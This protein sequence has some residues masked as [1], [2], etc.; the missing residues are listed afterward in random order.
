MVLTPLNHIRLALV[1]SALLFGALPLHADPSLANSLLQQ[2]R[3]DAASA[4]L[5]HALTSQPGDGQAHQLL[6]RVYYSQDM[7]DPAIHEC[8]LAAANAPNDSATQMWLGRAYGLKA[9]S[10]NPLS[11]FALAKK[12]RS[13]F[14]RAVQLDPGNARAMSDLGE[15]YVGA[16]A[17]IG[18]RLDKAQ[19]LAQ[20]KKPRSDPRTH[21]LVSESATPKT[22][23]DTATA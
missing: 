12:V 23:P 9:S 21:P 18:G 1:L 7:A 8:E 2:G 5:H 11:A 3:V 10:A 4:L 22:V 6:C 15:F 20:Q 16:P 14:E 19:T 13:A 17:I